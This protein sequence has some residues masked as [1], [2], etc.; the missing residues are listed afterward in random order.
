MTIPK[1]TLGIF[2]GS[3]G[4]GTIFREQQQINVKFTEGNLPFTDVS[5]T[6]A[7]NWKGKIK[8]IMVQGAHDGRGFDGVTDNQKLGDFIFEMEQWIRGSLE[9]LKIQDAVTY[10]DSLETEWDVK[11]FDFTWTRS[12]GDPNRVIYSLMLK[13]V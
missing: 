11:A 10:T 4:L 5:G 9:P 12:F 2:S 13:V 7:V 3:K 8:T 6:F 1:P